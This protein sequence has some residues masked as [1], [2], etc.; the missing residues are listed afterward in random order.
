M[1]SPAVVLRYLRPSQIDDLVDV[2]C[3]PEQVEML[4]L[5]V[6]MVLYGADDVQALTLRFDKYLCSFG[7]LTLPLYK[8]T[9]IKEY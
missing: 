5:D 7:G 6:P 2:L 9:K 8:V 3:C 1:I 4:G